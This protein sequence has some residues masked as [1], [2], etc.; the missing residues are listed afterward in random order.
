L[1]DHDGD[2]GEKPVSLTMAWSCAIPKLTTGTDTL[3]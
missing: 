2:K 1:K 3:D